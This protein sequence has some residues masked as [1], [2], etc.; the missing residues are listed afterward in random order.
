[1]P[2][3]CCSMLA[4]LPKNVF[5][6]VNSTVASTSP[7]TTMEPILA[8]L[9]LCM[10]TGRD[11]PV[12]ADWSTSIVP[13]LI[14]QSAGTA[15]PEPSSTRSPGTREPASSVVHLPSRLAVAKGFNEA[16]SAAT[17]SPALVV[18]YLRGHKVASS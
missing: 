17:A 9:P 1:M 10:V 16:L 12:S 15:E 4:V 3:S 14:K 6:P 18:S 8:L 7:R 13:W 5:L 11:S 2:V